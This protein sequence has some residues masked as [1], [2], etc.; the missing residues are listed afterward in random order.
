LNRANTV[1]NYLVKNGVPENLIEMRSMGEDFPD[2]ITKD[3]SQQQLNRTVGIYIL[4][5]FGTFSSF[6]LP[7]IENYVYRKE[8]EKAREARGLAN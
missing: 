1:R 3:G 6:P 8:V 5:G 7:L 2:I 4:K